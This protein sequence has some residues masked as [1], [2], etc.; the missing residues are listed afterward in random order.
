MI[1]ESGICSCT[2]CWATISATQTNRWR[3]LIVYLYICIFLW[4]ILR[5]HYLIIHSVEWLDHQYI[6]KWKALIKKQS[7]PTS[8]QYFGICL[9]SEENHENSQ[10]VQPTSRSSSLR[11]TSSTS[12]VKFCI[13]SPKAVY[14][15]QNSA[16]HFTD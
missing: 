7:C 9:E 10:S 2:Q 12:C 11:I 5:R 1:L 6:T 3:V 8:M 4:F 15:V 13:P 14:N 16:S